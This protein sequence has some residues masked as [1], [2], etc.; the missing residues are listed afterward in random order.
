MSMTEAID[1]NFLSTVAALPA[2]GRR[3]P[4]D[5]PIAP[6]LTGERALELFD[7]QLGSRHLDLAAR[8]LSAAGHG[9]YSIG[10]SGHEGNAAVADALRPTDPALLHYRSGAFYLRRAAQVPGQEPLRD[11]LL[12]ITASAEEP[13]A[14]G[15]HK[16]FGHKA[17]AVIPQTSTIASHLPRALGL[18][19]GLERAAK[20]GLECE[21]PADSVVV[22][23]FGD[24]SANH[25]TA[26]G[27][28]NAALAC[29]F[30]GLPMPL[31][32]VC[33]DNGIGISV[34]TPPGWIEAAYRCRAGL[35]YFDA[36]GADLAGVLGTAREAASYVRAE[37]SPAFLRLRTVRLMGHAGSD[38]ELSYR[39]SAEIAAD[40]ARDPL[41]A[42]AR[43][44]VDSRVLAAGD[45]IE[46]YERKR[47]QVRRLASRACGR[48]KLASGEEVIAPLAPAR[49]DLVASAS[50][51]VAA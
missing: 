40:H 44:L 4:P 10:S 20:L 30:Q 14:G 24:A 36:D 39:S 48:P 32:L 35:R 31:L 3:R 2:P 50:A 43:L 26:V 13:I 9:Y 17:L 29:R 12:G 28:I 47:A 8:E 15:R 21:W 45:V 46:L 41:L 25:S 11:V 22:C 42:T 38:V 16:V 6:G 51:T 18:A 23:S 34:R 19:F 33:E 7:A 5:E 37:R 49:P 27:A 1:E